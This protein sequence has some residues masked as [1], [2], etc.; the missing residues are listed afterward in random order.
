MLISLKIV[1]TAVQPF[2]FSPLYDGNYESTQFC[3]CSVLVQN[4]QL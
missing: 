1:I 2:Q 4:E 3:G